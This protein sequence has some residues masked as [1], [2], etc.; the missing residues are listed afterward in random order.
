M[1]FITAIC[2]LSLASCV[3][4][5]TTAPDGTV[6]KTTSFISTDAQVTAVSQAGATIAAAAITAE[7]EKNAG[8]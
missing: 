1:K 2:I 5:V 6:T 7:I 4:A 8:K 3:T